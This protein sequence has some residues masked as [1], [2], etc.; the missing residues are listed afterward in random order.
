[1]GPI[2]AFDVFFNVDSLFRN[3]AFFIRDGIAK[4]KLTKLLTLGPTRFAEFHQVSSTVFVGL[5]SLRCAIMLEIIPLAKFMN[6]SNSCLLNM[7]QAVGVYVLRDS[8]INFQLFHCQCLRF[9]L[10]TEPT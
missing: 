8:Q 2:I 3:E 4:L 1:M 10:D 5:S 7:F 9:F 6:E